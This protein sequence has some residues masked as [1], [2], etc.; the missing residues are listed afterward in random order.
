MDKIY[1]R[2]HATFLNLQLLFPIKRRKLVDDRNY[3]RMKSIDENYEAK[4]K[5]SSLI[6]PG[7]ESTNLP[8]T[9]FYSSISRYASHLLTNIFHIGLN[10]VYKFKYIIIHVV[11]KCF[12]DRVMLYCRNDAFH[13]LESL[14]LATLASVQNHV[15]CVRQ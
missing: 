1:I 7:I 14:I 9:E 2:T 4:N 11:L 15:M 13:P 10:S 6:L 8:Q 12:Y 5:R 3:H